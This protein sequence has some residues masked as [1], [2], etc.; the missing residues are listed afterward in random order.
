MNKSLLEATK[1][2]KT[3]GFS[4]I[5]VE[6]EGFMGRDYCENR[7]PC[8]NC[9]GKP[10]KECL[11]CD[12]LG[13][14]KGIECISCI[15]EGRIICTLC[16]GRGHLGAVSNTNNCTR[17][18]KRA[19]SKAAQNVLSYGM[20]YRDGSVD[21]EFTFTLP[22]EHSEY[23]IEYIEAFKAVARVCRPGRKMN[24]EGAGMHIAVIPTGC[25][26]RY[27][28]SVQLDSDKL[29]NFITQ[30]TKLLP[31]LF[32]L[33]SAG[34][35]TRAYNFRPPQISHTKYSAIALHQGHALEYRVF[36]TCYDQPTVVF[37]YIKV[38]ANT[39]RFYHDPKL[40]VK[41]IGKQFG[42]ATSHNVADLYN[43]EDQLRILNATVKF[44]K[45]ADKSF[46]QLKRQRGV[47]H[48]IGSL[49][50]DSSIRMSTLR[51]EYKRYSENY[52][53]LVDK[54]KEKIKSDP[55]L[56]R[57]HKAGYNNGTPD[58]IVINDLV[59]RVHRSKVSMADFIK[60]NINRRDYA[61]SVRV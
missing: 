44:L 10:D 9:S 47:Y 36:D 3:A 61:Y 6:L 30:V 20:F 12:G 32:F 21:S 27:P 43:T 19:V 5:K 53:S 28:T 55:D 59:K 42:F 13:V 2:I 37:D 16:V 50:K 60:N 23:I 25:N 49:K 31:A 39:L 7:L 52:D 22:I 4:H 57:Q 51:K 17:Y 54:T 45:P 29:N 18:M 33:G 34:P 58:E 41:S 26:G 56:L 35:K 8:P 15:G 46:R 11:N 48:T 40:T 14:S 38:I 24:V 1:F